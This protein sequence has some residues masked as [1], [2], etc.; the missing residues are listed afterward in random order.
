MRTHSVLFSC[1]LLLMFNYSCSEKESARDTVVTIK[2]P[3]KKVVEEQKLRKLDIISTYRWYNKTIREYESTVGMRNQYKRDLAD[4]RFRYEYDSL[5]RELTGKKMRFVAMIL[6]VRNEMVRVNTG[7]DWL[8]GWTTSPMIVVTNTAKV[9]RCTIVD[10]WKIG[11]KVTEERARAASQG[12]YME[13]FAVVDSIEYSK[14][15]PGCSSLDKAKLVIYISEV[16]E[17]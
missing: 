12:Q 6:E 7:Y 10:E 3:V 1:I 17:N 14:N 16:S 8:D 9:D 2:R 11:D 13:Y 4:A 5:R 15:K